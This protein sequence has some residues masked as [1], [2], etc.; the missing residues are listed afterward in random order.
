MKTVYKHVQQ[1]V[2]RGE[3]SSSPLS[4]VIDLSAPEAT[5]NGG[6]VEHLEV[7]PSWKLLFA[8]T[9]GD[10]KQQ[11]AKGL[12]GSFESGLSK[13]DFADSAASFIKHIDTLVTNSEKASIKLMQSI[14]LGGIAIRND[15]LGRMKYKALMLPF[16]MHGAN[17]RLLPLTE[18]RDISIM[19]DI[20]QEIIQLRSENKLN[21]WFGNV[22]KL[23]TKSECEQVIALH[24]AMFS[25]ETKVH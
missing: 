9:D 18:E 5:L 19:C 10:I 21:Q 20:L 22:V 23:I 4:M 14:G 11:F 13:A 24:S 3:G 8:G 1:A 12:A 6:T 17:Y 25:S 16:D 2:I 15:E 7:S